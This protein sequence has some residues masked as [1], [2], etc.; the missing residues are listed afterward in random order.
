LAP[1][2][3]EL[4]LHQCCGCMLA[5]LTSPL[6]ACTHAQVAFGPSNA[7]PVSLEQEAEVLGHLYAA[8]QRRLAAYKVGD[9]HACVSACTSALLVHESA[10]MKRRNGMVVRPFLRGKMFH[11][12]CE[13]LV[14][15]ATSSPCKITYR[16]LLSLPHPSRQSSI[17][18]LSS[19]PSL[20]CAELLVLVDFRQE[21]SSSVTTSLIEKGALYLQPCSFLA[22]KWSSISYHP[23]HLDSYGTLACTLLLGKARNATMRA[24][25]IIQML[26]FYLHCRT[27]YQRT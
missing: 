14:D 21:H 2:P 25:T 15:H 5:A 12:S 6:F 7:R 10:T 27:L 19:F 11:D 23:V 22:R 26:I 17:M 24:S 1:P 8:V 9:V 16:H 20:V 3:S 18:Y 4:R 13:R